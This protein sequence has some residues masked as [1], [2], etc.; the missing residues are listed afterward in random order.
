MSRERSWKAIL[1]R[2]LLSVNRQV[3][4]GSKATCCYLTVAGALHLSRAPH[5]LFTLPELVDVIAYS[6]CTAHRFRS[7]FLRSRAFCGRLSG[8]YQGSSSPRAVTQAS[9]SASVSGKVPTMA[10]WRCGRY[11]RCGG[12][13]RRVS[14]RVH[15]GGKSKCCFMMSLLSFYNTNRH[16]LPLIR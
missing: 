14:I 6:Q 4:I 9:V 3:A 1:E 10:L 15:V 7:R 16:L 12:V 2:L 13:R 8:R 11:P 5:A